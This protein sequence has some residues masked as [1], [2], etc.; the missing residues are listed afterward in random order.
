MNLNTENIVTTLV[1]GGFSALSSGVWWLI[2]RVITNVKQIELMQQEM[3]LREKAREADREMIRDTQ[4]EVKDI[5]H[6]L[7]ALFDQ[8]QP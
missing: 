4:S 7:D 1:I 5:R 2:R 3:R 6:R 8:N